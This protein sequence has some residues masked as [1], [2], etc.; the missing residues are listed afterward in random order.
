MSISSISSVDIALFALA[1][2]FWATLSSGSSPAISSAVTFCCTGVL[3]T[4]WDFPPFSIDSNKL[5]KY[6]SLEL[7]ISPQNYF[8]CLI[9]SYLGLFNKSLYQKINRIFLNTD[10]PV[11][12]LFSQLI[13]QRMYPI[14]KSLL[15]I[16]YYLFK[17]KTYYFGIL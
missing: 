7:I 17:R 11:S 8:L 1:V 16:K 12:N 3:S 14:H 2:V 6:S 13:N 15:I 9:L 4:F 10:T 5:S